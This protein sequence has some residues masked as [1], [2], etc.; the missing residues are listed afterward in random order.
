MIRARPSRCWNTSIDVRLIF[1]GGSNE[2]ADGIV[3]PK[4]TSVRSPAEVGEFLVGPVVVIVVE[5]G[6]G[7]DRSR[8]TMTST[9]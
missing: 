2:T 6:P 5:L 4:R 1:E 9:R 8:L 3:D 7:T